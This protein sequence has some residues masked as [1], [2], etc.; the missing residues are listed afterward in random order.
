MFF[1]SE[2][3]VETNKKNVRSNRTRCKTGENNEKT[4]TTNLKH[5]KNSFS[6]VSCEQTFCSPFSAFARPT[7]PRLGSIV[8]SFKSFLV[9]EWIENCL[10][11]LWRNHGSLKC[12]V[13]PSTSWTGPKAT[14][15]CCAGW[16]TMPARWL[17][18]FA[19]RD[20]IPSNW[21][22]PHVFAIAFW[23]LVM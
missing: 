4:T 11:F 7:A 10:R 13:F 21:H 1:G 20:A 8:A 12:A 6:S 15:A 22:G 2:Q 14:E 5:D 18:Q 19:T 16:E 9:F 23:F 3:E 17:T